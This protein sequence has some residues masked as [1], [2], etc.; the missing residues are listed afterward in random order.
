MYNAKCLLMP[1]SWQKYPPTKYL[2]VQIS[3]HQ[4]CVQ[5]AAIYRQT[6]ND[7]VS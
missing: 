4:T 6:V 7:N 3:L 5:T 2:E 1:S